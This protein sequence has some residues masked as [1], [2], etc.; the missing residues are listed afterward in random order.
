MVGR[1]A[2]S[3][4]ARQAHA[5]Q[6]NSPA[7]IAREQQTT[8][9]SQQPLLLDPRKGILGPR[10]ILNEWIAERNLHFSEHI[11][12]VSH[13][14]VAIEVTLHLRSIFATARHAFSFVE[15]HHC[16]ARSD[17]PGGADSEH[18]ISHPTTAR[19][20]HSRQRA[21]RAVDPQALLF[22]FTIAWDKSNVS[23]VQQV[24]PAYLVP[25]CLPLEAR[26][27][28][29][30]W[31]LVG[32]FSSHLPL[33][34]QSSL[35]RGQL[36]KV[37]RSVH[38][39]T[40][41][42]FTQ[43]FESRVNPSTLGQ[44][45]CDAQGQ[46]Q[47][48]VPLW[49]CLIVDYVEAAPA[50]QTR[51]NQTCPV[52]FLCKG[53]FHQWVVAER[54]TAEGTRRLIAQAR[55][56]CNTR[57]ELEAEM[58]E[59]GLHASDNP[60]ASEYAER[61]GFDIHRGLGSPAATLHNVF[62]GT[63][64]RGI[65]CTL[66][67]VQQTKTAAEWR[68][69]VHRLDVWVMAEASFRGR[70]TFSH[71]LSY[72]F[73][74]TDD[75]AG[76]PISFGKVTSKDVWK[77][78][79]RFWRVMLLDLLPD[80]NALQRAWGDYLHWWSWAQR[81][82]HSASTLVELDRRA[83]QMFASFEAVYG[84][85]FAL[86]VKFHLVMHVREFI[87]LHGSLLY[88]DD[89]LAEAAHLLGVKEPWKLTNH[90]DMESQMGLHTAQCSAIDELWENYLLAKRQSE[91]AQAALRQGLQRRRDSDE[92][93]SDEDDEQR[94][95][96]AEGSEAAAANVLIG[97]TPADR[98]KHALQVDL[99]SLGEAHEM[100]SQL[101]FALCLHLW[102]DQEGEGDNDPTADA[103]NFPSPDHP[104]LSLRPG[105]RLHTRLNSDFVRTGG[106]RLCGNVLQDEHRL[107]F[108]A[109][110]ADDA[111]RDACYYGQLVLCF[112]AQYL[113]TQMDLAYV[114]YLD[115]GPFSR[116]RGDDRTARCGP[117]DACRDNPSSRRRRS[118]LRRGARRR[119]QDLSMGCPARQERER[120]PE[121][122]WPVV[123]GPPCETC[124]AP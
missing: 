83:Q 105:I 116:G 72:Y 112:R 36:T 16:E 117:W 110:E 115:V 78:I 9:G 20:W 57:Q 24:F 76:A 71:G 15:A 123:R 10:A 30:W 61:A 5:S 102:C 75:H 100:L 80:D 77:D 99:A 114:R 118:L 17:R 88:F 82:A 11:V 48:V 95:A 79:L 90:R 38:L 51:Q 96:R 49:Q 124:D 4:A 7:V 37:R 101:E 69:L 42:V 50:S 14:G 94:G 59:L 113:G 63:V 89:A 43:E 44:R 26:R 39:K 86:C 54:R 68:A 58:K 22:P 98:R 34:V 2:L 97:R 3:S 52:C 28:R 60:L 62:E 8:K 6:A 47:T 67:R 18:M 70:T 109:I 65:T 108:V 81:P 66:R 121:G 122:G 41:Q 53:S 32:Y 31:I 1:D 103:D 23:K 33:H 55:Q 35:S 91:Q 74:A 92:D 40:M 107:D 106:R 12:Q 56:R 93:G 13:N 19:Y 84:D 29:R 120:P 21:I 46:R 111:N 85:E 25:N 73:Y 45:W 64:H 119:L 87:E 104:L 27:Q